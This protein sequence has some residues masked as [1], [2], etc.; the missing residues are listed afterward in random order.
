[1]T[2]KEQNIAMVF[3]QTDLNLQH[4]NLF[5]HLEK[6]KPYS[7]PPTYMQLFKFNCKKKAKKEIETK[8]TA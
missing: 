2:K 4:L 3:L 1:M 5:I 7:I 8:G 6:Y